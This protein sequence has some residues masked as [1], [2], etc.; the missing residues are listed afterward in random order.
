[1]CVNL[2][3]ISQANRLFTP[4]FIITRTF[5]RV[6]MAYNQGSL[7]KF[8]LNSIELNGCSLELI[9]ILTPRNTILII[10]SC[11]VSIPTNFN[12]WPVLTS[13]KSRILW[14]SVICDRKSIYLNKLERFI[15]SKLRIMW[16]F[17]CYKLKIINPIEYQLFL[18]FSI[19]SIFKLIWYI[20]S[21]FFIKIT[22]YNYKSSYIIVF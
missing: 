3:V 18:F 6:L 19:P 11:W 22:S 1:M 15:T 4:F 14:S 12:T 5:G 7:S 21:K 17:R 20:K 9:I 8:C 10:I 16:S 2:L 13:Q